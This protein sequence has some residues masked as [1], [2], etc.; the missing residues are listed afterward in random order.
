M[1]FARE[2]RSRLREIRSKML[3]CGGN[4]WASVRTRLLQGEYVVHKGRRL[5]LAPLLSTIPCA[6]VG[7]TT[8]PY[9]SLLLP[10][11]NRQP[12]RGRPPLFRRQRCS[13]NSPGKFRPVMAQGEAAGVAVAT[14]AL[15]RVISALRRRWI[16]R[17]IQKQQC[18][19]RARTPAMRH[20]PTANALI[21]P[22]VA[23][24]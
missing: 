6:G 4:R 14:L 7:T 2:N 18:V 13:E 3:G 9:R 19:P 21:E 12:D 16:T 23:A 11:G 1:A 22:A 5:K 20:R 8:P 24:E 17:H 10:K 15:E